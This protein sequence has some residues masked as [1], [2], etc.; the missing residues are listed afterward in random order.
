MTSAWA[1][2]LRRGGDRDY[3]PA[4]PGLHEGRSP[5]RSMQN[6]YPFRPPVTRR[7]PWTRE[8]EKPHAGTTRL[9]HRW[10]AGKSERSC[11]AVLSAPMRSQWYPEPLSPIHRR[12]WMSSYLTQLRSEV[13]VRSIPCIKRFFSDIARH[14]T[15]TGFK[16]LLDRIERASTRFHCASEPARWQGRTRRGAAQNLLNNDPPIRRNRNPYGTHLMRIARQFRDRWYHYTK[17][18]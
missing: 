14:L 13:H 8:A 16:L 15:P 11:R 3:P 1:T 2:A 12:T 17:V 7:N 6:T 10:K 9:L 4:L 5:N 18:P